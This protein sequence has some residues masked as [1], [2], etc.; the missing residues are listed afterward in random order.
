MSDGTAQPV[1]N[2]SIQ[3]TGNEALIT[4]EGQT[5]TVALT[6]TVVTDVTSSVEQIVV[7]YGTEDVDAYIRANVGTIT[8][9]FSDNTTKV[10]EPSEYTVEIDPG[11]SAA[12]YFG[13][14]GRYVKIPVTVVTL[15]CVMVEMEAED[16][17]IVLPYDLTDETEIIA[18]IKN[19]LVV[20]AWFSNS[21]EPVV[22]NAADY[23]IANYADPSGEASYTVSYEG[24]LS[25]DNFYII[26]GAAPVEITGINVVEENLV[27]PYGTEDILGYIKANINVKTIESD[28]GSNPV[29][30]FEVTLDGNVATVT[31]EGFDDT[32]TIIGESVEEIYADKDN[33]EI[34]YTVDPADADAVNAYILENVKV[35]Y[36]YTH[37]TA[38]AL[39]ADEDIEIAIEASSGVATLTVGIFTTTINVTFE[40]VPEYILDEVVNETTGKVY[41]IDGAKL[42]VFTDVMAGK[43]IFVNGVPAT[44]VGNNTYAYVVVGDYQ[45]TTAD[46]AAAPVAVE[47]GKLHNSEFVTAFDALLAL[48]K[49]LGN[50]VE[51]FDN[52][53]Q[54]YI[55]ADIDGDGVI[56]AT[57]AQMINN[58]SL[59]KTVN[60]WVNGS[61]AG[62]N[63]A[64][65]G[66]GGGA[67]ARPV[68]PE[69]N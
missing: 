24:M 14:T 20:T 69:L 1:T 66:A 26:R 29:T 23:S 46:M 34:P 39:V 6:Q 64:G 10:L 8:V 30:A 48:N 47:F 57:D 67:G 65:G 33:I 53:I 28:G 3:I 50:A 61:A 42:L 56:D 55:L 60:T 21:E 12:V 45:I 36:A 11:S 7:P 31:Y 13:T 5:D 41:A 18:Y 52:N 51:V 4:Y 58:I 32:L 62:G 38:D 25:A 15:D 35:Y 9:H 59:G 22:V 16:R 17:T 37:N 27:I 2:Y 54:N 44:Y 43:G 19:A 68:I 49:G 40:P 63:A